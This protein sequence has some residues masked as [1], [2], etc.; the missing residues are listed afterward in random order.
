MVDPIKN[1]LVRNYT[2]SSIMPVGDKESSM[3]QGAGV[4]T[5]AKKID[6]NPAYYIDTMKP[7]NG[8]DPFKEIYLRLKES[9]ESQQ[10][11]VEEVQEAM[12]D[13]YTM[14][15]KMKSVGLDLDVMIMQAYRDQLTLD[16]FMSQVQE[17]LYTVKRADLKNVH[18]E[19]LEDLDKLIK[20]M[21]SAKI[22]GVSGQIFGVLAAI[23]GGITTIATGGAAAVFGIALLAVTLVNTTENILGDPMKRAIGRKVTDG[24]DSSVEKF[25]QWCNL[26]IG[27][28]QMILGLA[29]TGATIAAARSAQMGAEAATVFGK[30]S[31]HIVNV[32]NGTAHAGEGVTQIGKAA[33]DY[34]VNRVRASH[35]E[36]ETLGKRV[37][38]ELKDTL[39]L[40]KR[41][42]NNYYGHQQSLSQIADGQRAAMQWVR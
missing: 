1:D 5:P 31:Q 18:K 35:L 13:L 27:V 8:H 20:K 39:E 32:A 17:E 26:G 41:A 21:K 16:E 29:A 9:A 28:L 30:T 22:W 7:D 36:N 37:D 38:Q 19:Q 14:R 12:G 42:M 40:L 33:S 2:Q 10:I 4:S 34:Q 24:S 25:N 15:N 6:P 3:V 23:M 11:P